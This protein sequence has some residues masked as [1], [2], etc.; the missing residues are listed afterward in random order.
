MYVMRVTMMS[1]QSSIWSDIMSDQ[2]YVWSD[3]MG[4]KIHNCL[5]GCVASICGISYNATGCRIAKS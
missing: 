1:Y 3:I 2:S 4:G 5:S